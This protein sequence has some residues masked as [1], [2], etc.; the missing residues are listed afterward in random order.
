MVGIVSSAGSG[1]VGY[2]A[3]IT[4]SMFNQI[5]AWLTQDD[6]PPPPRPIA[7]PND[8]ALSGQRDRAVRFH[9]HVELRRGLWRP[10]QCLRNQSAGGAELVQRL[11]AER[12]AG[13]NC[14]TAS[15]TLRSDPD[16]LGAFA[17]A[18][19]EQAVLDAGA[20]PTS[21]ITAIRRDATRPSIA[22]TTSPAIPISSMLSALT[23]TP[24]PISIQSMDQREGRTTT[25][26][27]LDYIAS[28]S[29]LIG[30]LGADERAG[31]AHFIDYGSREGR[32]T[33][34]DGL[35]YIAQYTGPDEGFRREQR[36]RRDALYRLWP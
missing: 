17:L 13:G 33:T 36:R 28:Y 15:T 26:D 8:L 9:R 7:N 35:A 1:G 3:Q 21:S 32:T 14:T 27:G 20:G 18:G 6:P 12:A 31:A 24:E 11:R 34:F 30:A 16:L 4:T 29:D 23:A 2:F 5:E 25:F 10:H 22:S 19:S